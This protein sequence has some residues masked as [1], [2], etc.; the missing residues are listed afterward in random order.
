MSTHLILIVGVAWLLFKNFGA[1]IFPTRSGPPRLPIV[2]HLRQIP[3]KQP[4]IK[5]AE[6]KNTYGWFCFSFHFHTDVAQEMLFTFRFLGG[7]FLF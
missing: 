4:W 2:G 7:A 5:F 6:W 3:I 1:T